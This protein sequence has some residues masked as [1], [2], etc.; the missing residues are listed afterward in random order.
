MQHLFRKLVTIANETLEDPQVRGGKQF[1]RA[2]QQLGCPTTLEQLADDGISQYSG[3]KDAVLRMLYA[4]EATQLF[5]RVLPALFTEDAYQ[6]LLLMPTPYWF[7]SS[8]RQCAFEHQV[9]RN[10]ELIRV[11]GEVLLGNLVCNRSNFYMAF[12]L[13]AVKSVSELEPYELA[14]RV[15]EGAV[16]VDSDSEALRFNPLFAPGQGRFRNGPN[17]ERELKLAMEKMRA[18]LLAG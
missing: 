16:L 3:K 6:L 10:G 15:A 7:W 2:L 8:V 13:D 4:E 12:N 18:A 17:Q 1:F 14:Y 9:A 11:T 5:R